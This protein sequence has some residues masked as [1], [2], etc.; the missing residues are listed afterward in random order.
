MNRGQIQRRHC[1]SF[2]EEVVAS[3]PSSKSSSWRKQLTAA[4]Q[5]RHVTEYIKNSKWSILKVPKII[6]VRSEKL[7]LNPDRVT[8]RLKL[9]GGQ[10]DQRQSS[11]DNT[12]LLKIG[13]SRHS[14]ISAVWGRMRHF[15][16]LLHRAKKEK[17]KA[18]ESWLSEISELYLHPKHTGQLLTFLWKWKAI[19]PSER[20]TKGI[21]HKHAQRHLLKI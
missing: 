16:S 4:A 15:F 18:K 2:I 13:E 11:H 9:D 7:R 21:S 12:T 5:E 20:Q 14:R 19:G 1:I 6:P 10:V 3:L 8:D 17:K